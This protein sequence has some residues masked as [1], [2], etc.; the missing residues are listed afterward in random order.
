MSDEA[1]AEMTAKLERL[2][3]FFEAKQVAEVEQATEQSSATWKAKHWLAAHWMKVVGLLVALGVTGLEVRD[4]WKT[5]LATS[6]KQVEQ[7]ATDETKLDDHVD[8]AKTTTDALK[9]AIIENQ[10]TT[11]EAFEQVSK[12]MRVAHPRLDEQARKDAKVSPTLQRAKDAAK[13]AKAAKTLF[14]EQPPAP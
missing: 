12:E 6:A 3:G 2:T 10:V 4:Q 5:H 14:V 8:D 11:V 9:Q 7:Q 1:I 13:R